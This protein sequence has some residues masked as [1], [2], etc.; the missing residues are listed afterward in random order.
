[1]FPEPLTAEVARVIDTLRARGLKLATAES[2]TGGLLS[3]LFTEIAGSSDVFERGFV[4][5]SNASKIGLLN[6][7]PGLIAHHGAVSAEVA[8]AMAEGARRASA[9]GLALSVTGVAGPGQ[10]ERKPVGLVFLG[11]AQPGRA[12]ISEECR[13]GDKPRSQIRLETVTAALA[14]LARHLSPANDQIGSGK[15]AAS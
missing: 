15:G 10:S 13:F 14:F 5:Y 9:A 1:M 3:G 7:D 12:A 4:T 2:C 11:L 8:R 6:V